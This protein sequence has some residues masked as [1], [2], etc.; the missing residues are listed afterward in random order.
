MVGESKISSMVQNLKDIGSTMNSNRVPI[1]GL[2]AVLMLVLS[3]VILL[4]GREEF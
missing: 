1:H 4:K 3:K 2:M